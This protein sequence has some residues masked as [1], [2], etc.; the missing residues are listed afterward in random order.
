MNLR[1]SFVL[2]LFSSV[3]VFASDEESKKEELLHRI[4][5]KYHSQPTSQDVWEK[6]LGERA[7]KEYTVV[8]GDTLW[9]VSRTLF[10]DGFFWSKVWSLN[11]YITN[12]HQISVGQVVHFFP[13]EGLDAPGL[14]VNTESKNP[15]LTPSSPLLNSKW[16]LSGDVEPIPI[17]LSGVTIPPPVKTH[18]KVLD[19]FPSSLPNWYFQT[20]A[21]MDQAPLEITPM[22]IVPVNN[23][24]NLPFFISEFPQNVKGSVYEIEKNAKTAASND[25]LFID[26]DEDLKVGETYTVIQPI[27]KIKDPEAIDDFPFSYEIEGEIKVIARVQDYYKAIVTLALFPI[28]VGAKIIPGRAPKMN[29]TEPGEYASL[30]GMIIGG[31]NDTGA[32]LFGPQSIVFINR[33]SGDG[34][35]VNQWAPIMAVHRLRHPESTIFA[36]TWKLGEVKVVKV[37]KNYCTAII[38]TA[39]EGVLP[40]DIVGQLKPT[41]L[42]EN[43]KS[44]DDSFDFGDDEDSRVFS[45]T[46]RK[47]REELEKEKLGKDSFDEDESKD[48]SSSDYSSSDD[49]SSDDFSGDEFGSDSDDS[50][51]GG[52]KDKSSDG[53][54]KHS[55]SSDDKSDDEFEDTQF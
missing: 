32:K 21:E 42:T 37:E 35:K 54:K 43:F 3:L 12:P 23:I 1:G 55:D 38:M 22:K 39:T 30:Q 40:G 53:E 49:S 44:L 24:L 5:Q 46:E 17:D 26:A 41:D 25:Y 9:D 6:A 27:G 10:A 52:K 11:P 48:D 33:G 31:E 14:K 4:Y 45:E 8:K 50:S 34:V 29:M 47:R 2:I 20:D 51:G 28:Q 13:G 16:W 19:V 7:S 18:N 15:I 36:N